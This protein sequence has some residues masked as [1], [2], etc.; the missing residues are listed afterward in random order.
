MTDKEQII[1]NKKFIKYGYCK[2]KLDIKHFK[3]INNLFKKIVFKKAGIKFE[4]KN[5]HKSY[6]LKKLNELRLKI[7]SE[8]NKKMTFKHLI[9]NSA[10]KY[11]NYSVGSELCC[12]DANLSIQCPEE[13]TSLLNM[14][15]DLDGGESLFQV[16][17]WF[18]FM[19]VKK[20]QSMFVVDPKTSLK[21]LE[22]IK[23]NKKIDFQKINKKYENHLKWIDVKLGEA[24][25]FSPNILHGNVVNREKFTRFSINIRFKN[26]YSPQTSIENEKR[27]GTFYKPL[28]LKT[29]TNFNLKH[30]FTDLFN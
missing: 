8:I 20:T 27:L 19:N 24:I 12:G 13:T 21:I 7:F 10:S 15:A 11:I 25:L 2:F 9:Y 5:F 30:N 23:C 17:L 22:E 28:T 26:V 1:F 6:D 18:P 29:I 4:L 14:H 16:N 3:K